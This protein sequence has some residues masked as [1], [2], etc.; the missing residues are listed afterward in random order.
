MILYNKDE[1]NEARGWNLDLMKRKSDKLEVEEETNV[2]INFGGKSKDIKF[3]I[4]VITSFSEINQIL[5]HIEN[6]LL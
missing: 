5:Y 6:V 1:T 2:A 3:F 4:W